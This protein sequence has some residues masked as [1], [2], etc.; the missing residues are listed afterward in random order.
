MEG[1]EPPPS[2]P[3]PAS[4][5]PTPNG[6]ALPDGFLQDEALQGHRTA[7][8]DAVESLGKVEDM[9]L[10]DHH[11][12][13]Y[14]RYKGLPRIRVID[15]RDPSNWHF[16]ALP[17]NTG[18]TR[19]GCSSGGGGDASGDAG[20]D[21]GGAPWPSSATASAS[22]CVLSPGANEDSHSPTLRFTTSSPLSA[23]GVYDY[24]MAT[25]ELLVRRET[26]VRTS[27]PSSPPPPSPACSPSSPAEDLPVPLEPPRAYDREEFVCHRIDVPCRN[28]E[29]TAS[30]P[31]T[32]V[33]RKDL[34]TD[35][36]HP[37][38]LDC[39]GAYGMTLEPEF[40]PERLS[41][42]RRGWVVAHAHV[43][44]GGELGNDWY[45]AGRL[46]RK[47]NTFD[48]LAAVAN[49]LVDLGYTESCRMAVT[50][51]SAGGLAVGAVLN[52]HPGLF[53]A[54]SMHA[55]FLDPLAAMMDPS[56]P[57]T[58]HEYDEWG[59]PS[60]DAAVR[61]YIAG[62]SPCDNIRDAPIRGGRAGK[63]GQGGEQGGE[64]GRRKQGGQGRHPGAQA[65]FVDDTYPAMLVTCALNDPRVE[66]WQPAK[67][68]AML[69][70]RQA[71]SSRHS[72][73]ASASAGVGVG[74][75]D[76]SG[77]VDGDGILLFNCDPEDTG[78]FGSGGRHEKYRRKAT[79]VAFFLRQ[80]LPRGV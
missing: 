38:L 37:L 22:V 20:E 75:G 2:S 80:C 47:R 53:R 25:R 36:S 45:D 68:V 19:A 50:G 66:Y 41:L 49:A 33:H 12:V 32:L 18:G 78:H 55:P 40:R 3:P 61:E 62:Y 65:G 1:E 52:E 46:G 71:S 76:E 63:G 43:R 15:R 35:G 59:D 7:A 72:E 74:A 13:L 21:T 10:F 42:L 57:L 48:D 79:E 30:V 56:L 31:V 26:R 11:V 73:D 9:D 54:A 69:R 17:G 23:E 34:V 64:Q 51:S 14:E 58:V 29:G 5:G 4:S 6:C 77:D 8:S 67:W 70:A 60:R 27:S 24:N 39:Y 28:A 16:V 44:G